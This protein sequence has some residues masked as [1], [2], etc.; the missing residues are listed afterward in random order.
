M[1]AST[2]DLQARRS[3][4]ATIAS[5]AASTGERYADAQRLTTPAGASRRLPPLEVILQL[6]ADGL[7]NAAIACRYR[8]APSAVSMALRRAREAAV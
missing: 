8:V 4:G 7:S 3:A 5:I 6:K 1:T 2:K